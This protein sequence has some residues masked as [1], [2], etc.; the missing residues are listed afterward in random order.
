MKNETVPQ[1]SAN[2]PSQTRSGTAA[3][4]PHGK[5]NG[6]SNASDKHMPIGDPLRESEVRYRRLFESAQDGI[7]ILDAA[8]GRITDANSVPGVLARL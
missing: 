7:L 1:I 3:I 8:T 6:S 4:Q 5:R 2:E